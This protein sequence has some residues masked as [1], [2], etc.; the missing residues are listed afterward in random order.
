MERTMRTTIKQHAALHAAQARRAANIEATAGQGRAIE[1]E[2]ASTKRDYTQMEM[3]AHGTTDHALRALD[4]LIAIVGIAAA[5]AVTT[6]LALGG[7]DL[8]RSYLP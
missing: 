6:W 4:I 8:I 1:R 7:I 2:W 5:S 3:N